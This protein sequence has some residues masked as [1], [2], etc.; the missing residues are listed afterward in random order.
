[1]FAVERFC[2]QLPAIH[3]A[4]EAMATWDDSRSSSKAEMLLS[5]ISRTEFLVGVFI[6]EQLAS[7]L[8]PLALSLQEKG[9]DLVMALE[10][11]NAV[12]AEI[13]G[14]RSSSE[15]EFAMVMAR[16]ES[17]AKELGDQG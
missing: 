9:A 2:E 14:L 5:S 11:I 8:R 4:L 12:R 16:V 6:A 1:M 15:E 13:Q 10:L 17:A 7:I 3:H